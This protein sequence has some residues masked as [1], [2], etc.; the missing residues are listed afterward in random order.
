MQFALSVQN[1]SGGESEVAALELFLF[2]RAAPNAP[3]VN[4]IQE[5]FMTRGMVAELTGYSADHILRLAED[6]PHYVLGQRTPLFMRSEILTWFQER[7]RWGSR[8]PNAAV[9]DERP[10]LMPMSDDELKQARARWDD[11]AS[12]VPIEDRERGRVEPTGS[13]FVTEPISLNVRR[14]WTKTMEKRTRR[15]NVPRTQ[16]AKKR[17]RRQSGR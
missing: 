17:T 15:Q 3:W 13:V 16:K 2:C 8:P 14:T 11:L 12:L 9:L 1:I 10:T 5:T 4:V 6:L 7:A